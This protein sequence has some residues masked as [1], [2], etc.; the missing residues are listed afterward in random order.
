MFII[1]PCLPRASV[2]DPKSSP[3]S[4]KVQHECFG[5]CEGLVLPEAYTSPTARYRSYSDIINS[6]F[7]QCHLWLFIEGQNLYKNALKCSPL[8]QICLWKY[9]TYFLFL[10][11]FENVRFVHVKSVTVSGAGASSVSSA[12]V[13]SAL[14]SLSA[15]LTRQR[16]GLATGDSTPPTG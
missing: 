3:F 8:E 6:C 1:V 4:F 13:C 16:I 10:V 5:R 12:R 9:Q 15:T 7:E 2:F 11:L 14:R